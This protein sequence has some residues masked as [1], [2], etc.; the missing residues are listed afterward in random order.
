MERLIPYRPKHKSR[1]ERVAAM[2]KAERHEL[3]ILARQLRA[4]ARMEALETVI[5]AA[6]SYHSE[7]EREDKAHHGR[8][9]QR[10]DYLCRAIAD[11]TEAIK[12]GPVTEDDLVI[13]KAA[14]DGDETT[15]KIEE[16]R[17]PL[18][19]IP[20]EPPPLTDFDKMI[21]GRPKRISIPLE[22][23]FVLRKIADLLRG[24]AIVMDFESRRPDTAQRESLSRIR[25]EIGK[26]NTKIREAALQAGIYWQEGA[27]TKAERKR[28]EGQT[29]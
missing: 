14:F 29:P 12:A 1:R 13:A 28:R 21:I 22:D 18:R 3:V 11:A 8:L 27:S 17:P 15:G 19:E 9:R 26:T 6:L 2:S 24:L 16:Q 25:W 7:T 20:P 23:K 10:E 5:D 4:D